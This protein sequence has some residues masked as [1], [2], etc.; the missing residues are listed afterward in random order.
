MAFE[1]MDVDQV[2]NAGQQLKHQAEQINTVI[3]TINGLVS[4][5]GQVWH[6]KDATDFEG[7]WN[8]QHRPALVAAAQAIEGLGQSAL[9]NAEAQRTTSQS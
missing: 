4:H 5:L 2:S 3:N 6:G 1:G 8:S 9:N 7:W